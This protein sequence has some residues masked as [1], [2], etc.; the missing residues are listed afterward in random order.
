MTGNK[1]FPCRGFE[2]ENAGELH[3]GP[4]AYADLGKK[5]QVT[6]RYVKKYM[7]VTAESLRRW[8]LQ[9]SDAATEST[10][11]RHQV[12]VASAPFCGIRCI[13]DP[14]YL[15]EDEDRLET[16]RLRPRGVIV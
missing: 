16:R 2:K 11:Q 7:G 15:P 8:A 5:L 10:G 14:K 9:L 13:A 12:W 4:V 1:L 3:H 6:K